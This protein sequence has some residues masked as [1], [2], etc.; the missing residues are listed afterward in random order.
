MCGF[1]GFAVRSGL[2]PRDT[3]H[4]M[5][6]SI[7]HRG[8]DDFGYYG[9]DGSK[10]QFWRQGVGLER[11]QVGLGFRRLSILDLSENGAQPMSTPD[12]RFCLAFNGQI[13]NYNELRATLPGV[14][15]RSTSDTEVLLHI[16]A[17]GGIS[18]LARLNGMYAFSFFDSKTGE[19]VLARDP[20]G[21]KP[22][23]YFVDDRGIF[24]GSE[25]RTLL[26][27]K[28]GKPSL[29]RELLGRYLMNG[30]V[31]D[32]DTLFEGIARVTP[33]HY[34]TVQRNG[35]VEEHRFWNLSSQPEKGVPYEEW[36][37][38]L[39][40]TLD[41]A[42]NRQMR[43]DVPLGFFLSGGVDSSLLTARAAQMH[44]QKPEAFSVGFQWK[45]SQSPGGDLRASR[46]IGGRFAINRHEILLAPRVVDLLPKVV[47][48]L[49]EP[50]ADSAAICSYLICE[51]AK[52]KVKVLISGQ[53]AD[54]I[55]GG[56]PTYQ[57]GRV[58][59]GLQSMPSSINNLMDLTAKVL[60]YSMRGR[61]FQTIH[62]MKKVFTAVHTP[63]PEPFLLLRSPFQTA[64]MHALLSPE[65]L[66][67]QQPP[68]GKHLEWFEEAK[69][70]DRFAQMMYL[71]TKT[72]L[73]ALNLAYSDK[74]SMAHSMELR[75]PFLDQEVVNLSEKLPS[76]Y[77]ASLRGSKIMLKSVAARTLPKSIVYRRKAGFAPP[78]R[79]WFLKDLQPMAADLLSPDRLRRQGLFHPELPSI[80]LKEHREMKAD[81]CTK[82][83]TLMT[84]QLWAES[85]GI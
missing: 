28:R 62:R 10:G 5:T 56:Y 4:P 71:D 70:W 41:R 11:V 32:P 51:A 23:Y 82:L 84:F 21:I 44:P 55:F 15:W 83:Y 31:P 33:G 27:V 25:I 85:Q 13:Y 68:F 46:V 38:R 14:R 59:A 9:W 50:I 73:P 1:A 6:E 35:Q 61:Q 26:A 63:W 2:D 67:S 8:P 78:L 24:F 57:A 52:N 58:T 29:R 18:A 64:Q 12:G 42:L 72:Y 17:Q 54:E 39:A 79:D 43:S 74:T 47:D 22:L 81:H 19:M 53:G 34:L 66:A 40:G 49:E 30:W 60:P 37:N 20:L 77:K 65:I 36:E 7:A 69:G 45:T 16:L 76:R 3:L 80:W 75:V 48:I